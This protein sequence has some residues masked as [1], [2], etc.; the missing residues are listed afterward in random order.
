MRMEN[1]LKHEASMAES[2]DHPEE[3]RRV[4]HTIFQ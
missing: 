1:S 4:M 3:D 2:R